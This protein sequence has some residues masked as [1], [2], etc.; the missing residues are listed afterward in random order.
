M[1][2]QGTPPVGA[3]SFPSFRLSIG[4]D[5]A[6]MSTRAARVTKG[7]VIALFPTEVWLQA[8]VGAAVAIVGTMACDE[9]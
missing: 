2:W 1:S 4:Y 6:S 9:M 7:T 3:S 5:V 8:V